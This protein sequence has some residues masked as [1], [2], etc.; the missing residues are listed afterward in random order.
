MA[1]IFVL[2]SGGWGIAM[3]ITQANN[4]H[5]VTI[6]SAFQNEIDVLTEKRCN[7]N[8]LP[9]VFLPESIDIT[10]DISRAKAADILVMAVPS[11]AVRSVAEKLKEIADGKLIVSLSKGFDEGTG[12]RLSQVIK[13]NLPSSRVV[14]LSGPSHAE[15]VAFNTPTLC[16]CASEI[17]KD[18]TYIRNTFSTD[19]FRLYDSDDVAGVEIG[20]AVKN[21]MALAS[22]IIDG[23]GLGDNSKA[24]LMTRGIAEMKRLGLEMGGKEATFYGLAG[25]G[26]LIVTCGSTH[27]R[28]HEAGF[29]IGE[30][31]TVE[32]AI[33][34]VGKTVESYKT[35]KA[36][37][38]LAQ[39]YGVEMPIADGVYDIIYNGKS[40][41]EVLINLMSRDLTKE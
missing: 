10:G 1:D 5:K 18:A 9:N 21:V 6:W 14:V 22:G 23:M 7:A 12:L 27:S 36:V 39:K 30:G 29:Y 37:H 34:K 32:G 4:G 40:A 2:G 20:G 25:I 35:T 8:L 28:N 26:D 38:E 15:E 31:M 41:K 3:A 13:E 17:A 16:V 33:A 24:A 19:S 11:G